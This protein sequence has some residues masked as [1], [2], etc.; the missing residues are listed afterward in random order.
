MGKNRL[1]I[2]FAII[3]VICIFSIAAVAEQCKAQAEEEV[4]VEGAAVEG[5]DEE[6]GSLH[7]VLNKANN[8]IVSITWQGEAEDSNGNSNSF[9]AY[10]NGI[11]YSKDGYIITSNVSGNIEKITVN[12]LKKTQFSGDLVGIDKNNNIS[13][14]KIDAQNMERLDFITAE[15]I[16]VGEAVV[17]VCKTSTGIMKFSQGS[18]TATGQDINM[19]Q[20]APPLVD[21]I[22]TDIE[23]P[24]DAV[25]GFLFNINSEVI[26]IN[27]VTDK[28]GDS[29]YISSSIA[30]SIADKIIGN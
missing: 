16:N 26:G 6:I 5:Q 2:I 11:I 19:T 25:G 27:A 15:D 17:S 14:I 4:V 10:T 3:A 13:V 29:F 24:Q 1:S 22:K 12:L 8:A 30:T 20:D 28:S 9:E 7:N 23:L 18:I 21:L